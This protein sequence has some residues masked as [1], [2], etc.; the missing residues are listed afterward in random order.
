MVGRTTRNGSI[1]LTGTIC[2]RMVCRR[3]RL[4]PARW[5][6]KID[7]PKR[8]IIILD[9]NRLQ[10]HSFLA[11]LVSP[12]VAQYEKIFY[13]PVDCFLSSSYP[14]GSTERSVD[15]SGAT[16]GRPGA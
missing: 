16:D 12:N 10:F 2:S 8:V 14:D 7:R 5:P 11:T 1:S 15:E 3:R 4:R 9:C 6:N 13:F